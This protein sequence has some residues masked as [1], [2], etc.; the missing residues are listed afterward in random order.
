LADFDVL[1][2]KATDG[3]LLTTMGAPVAQAMKFYLDVGLVSKDIDRFRLQLNKF[4][5]GSHT[6]TKL[7]EDKIMRNL[8]DLMGARSALIPKESMADL[9]SFVENC[10]S[11]YVSQL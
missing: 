6:G 8:A 4:F 3:A 2:I 1:L 5:A 10:R 9:K 7:V 11:E